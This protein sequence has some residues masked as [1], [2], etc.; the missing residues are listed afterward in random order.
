[1][2]TPIPA[3]RFDAYWRLMR[4]DKPIGILLLLW[5]GLWALWIAGQGHPSPYVVFVIV[6]GTVLMRAAGCVINDYADRD[7][8]PHVERTKLRP[9]A[10]GE[11]A[12]KSALWLFVALCLVA[13]A[14]VLTLNGLTIALSVP[15]ALLAAS[16]PFMKRYTHWPQAYLGLA[17]GWAVP[18]SFAAETGGVPFIAWEI[19]AATILWALIYD[20][21]YAMVDRDDDI[22]I[23][24][25]STAILFGRHDRLILTL[26]QALMLA[27][28]GAVGWQADL[29]GAYY[30]GLA[31]A[32]GLAGYQQG[33]IRERGKPECFRAFLNNNWFGLAVFAGLALDYALR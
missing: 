14:L 20:T 5:P 23:G 22:R 29:G 3:A 18:M 27:I 25:K 13:F 24:V 16:Y 10:A 21:M 26:L 12:P 31:V 15:G 30:A 9:I 6:L 32:A 17:F 33:L 1:M 2:M 28:L 11:I 19:Y 4:F 8:D 7:F